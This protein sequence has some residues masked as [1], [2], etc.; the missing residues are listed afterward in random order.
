MSTYSAPK[1]TLVSAA[2]ANKQCDCACQAED[3]NPY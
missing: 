2:L 1:T 3:D